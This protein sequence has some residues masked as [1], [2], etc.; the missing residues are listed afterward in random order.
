MGK[1]FYYISIFIIKKFWDFIKLTLLKNFDDET[2]TTWCITKLKKG[3]K[4]TDY[5][6]WVITNEKRK[7]T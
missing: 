1:S 4:R 2:K 7:I 3:K 6:F 5:D